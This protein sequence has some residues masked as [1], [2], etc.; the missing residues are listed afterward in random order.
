MKKRESI[1]SR[2][3]ILKFTGILMLIFA[4]FPLHIRGAELVIAIN[5][6]ECSNYYRS[7]PLLTQLKQNFDIKF[8]FPEYES[9]IATKYLDQ[10]LNLKWK[11]YQISYNDSLYNLYRKNKTSEC[12]YFPNESKHPLFSFPLA[13]LDQS[14]HILRTIPSKFQVDTIAV[15]PRFM[16][17]GDMSFSFDSNYFYILDAQFGSI[18]QMDKTTHRQRFINLADSF[19][20]ASIQKM[21]LNPE[22][23]KNHL[24]LESTMKDPQAFIKNE[25]SFSHLTCHQG[26]LLINAS[27]VFYKKGEHD[28]IGIYPR[29]FI[30][31]INPFNL[32]EKD[33]IP[34][35]E[36]K[37]E[38]FVHA[39]APVFTT[40][41]TLY[42]PILIPKNSSLDSGK[43]YLLASYTLKN[44]QLEYQ[45]LSPYNLLPEEHTRLNINYNYLSYS[46]YH[47]YFSFP[48]TKTIYHT[49]GPGILI[50]LLPEIDT[51]PGSEIY[52]IR[53][54]YMK[55]SFAVEY[56]VVNFLVLFNDGKIKLFSYDYSNNLPLNQ[57]DMPVKLRTPW[58]EEDFFK[59]IDINSFV[60]INLRNQ[61]MLNY[62]W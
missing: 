12:V 54:N 35:R 18:L 46:T 13:R 34:Y 33:C 58:P 48:Y 10:K 19:D 11:E 26:Q 39:Y 28:R 16:F 23:L 41:D 38:I 1:N 40:G 56:P 15:D 61:Y 49:N 14:L 42:I 17:T 25:I 31:R 8:I 29:N 55:L 57:I 7:A 62:H 51:L 36:A 9:R 2:Q 45:G 59:F 24:S 22:E 44:S 3:V 60:H 50:S 37:D 53:T 20:Y 4:N 6:L 30:L 21:V 5:T 52:E 47:N 32:R 27:T 43:K